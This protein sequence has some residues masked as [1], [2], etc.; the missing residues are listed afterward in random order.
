MRDYILESLSTEVKCFILTYDYTN[1]C[2]CLTIDWECVHNTFYAANATFWF[3]E[4]SC[5][6]THTY[7]VIA[8]QIKD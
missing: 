4:M 5:I 3:Q 7:A 1:Y 8:T 6:Y 2:F